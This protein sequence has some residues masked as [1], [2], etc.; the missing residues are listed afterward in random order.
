MEQ[1]DTNQKL[2]S[3]TPPWVRLV[4]ESINGI[5]KDLSA[6]AEIKDMR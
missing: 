6:L 3:K 4:Q 2:K 1:D 5:R